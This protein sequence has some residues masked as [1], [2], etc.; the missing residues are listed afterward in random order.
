MVLSTS[1][2]APGAGVYF[3]P[4]AMIRLR[5]HESAAEL[6][7]ISSI[8]EA[9]PSGL[10]TKRTTCRVSPLKN[11]AA[12]TL[13]LSEAIDNRSTWGSCESVTGSKSRIGS[14][15]LRER[16]FRAASAL[17]S[18]VV[19]KTAIRLSSIDPAW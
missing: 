13:S 6:P 7:H 15:D 10:K 17:R 19:N 11:V 14:F 1:A 5:S 4:G 12:T 8:F 16:A 9:S 3:F 18:E 2:L